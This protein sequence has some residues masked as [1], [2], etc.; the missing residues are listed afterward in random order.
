VFGAAGSALGQSGAVWEALE[1]EYPGVF[2]IER[3]ER[4][5]TVFGRPMTRGATARVAMED[6]MDLYQPV[7]GVEDL[8]W[9]ETRGAEHAD[10][11]S[12]GVGK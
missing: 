3:G 6:W 9:V 8:E 2:A 10:R 5:T 7:F 12:V 1:G 4:V 11:S